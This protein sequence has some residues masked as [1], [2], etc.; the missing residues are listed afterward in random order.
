[1]KLVIG[2]LHIKESRLEDI[3]VGIECIKAHVLKGKHY[4]QIILLGDLTDKT[5]TIKERVYVTQFLSFLKENTDELVV[6]QGTAGH[7]YDKSGMYNLEDIRMLMGF[8]ATPEYKVGKLVFLH[9]ELKGAVYANGMRVK[10]DREVDNSLIYVAGHIHKPQDFDNIHY[11]G[12]IFKV[13]FAEADDTKRILEIDDDNNFDYIDIDS[14]P[15]HQIDL[16]GKAGVVKASN[17][18]KDIPTD[19]AINLKIVVSSDSTSL[20]QLDSYIRKIRNKFNITHYQQ[21][22]CVTDV[23]VKD[24][25]VDIDINKAIKDFCKLR[26]FNYKLVTEEL[27][28]I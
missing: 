3:K 18:I 15:M 27:K 4:N 9:E 1:M 13:S 11:V 28:R 16:V 26:K 23:S 24:S 8:K 12:S 6:I 7:D 22:K 17:T 20:L 10:S 5:P 19:T 21:T 2:D 14:V 25:D